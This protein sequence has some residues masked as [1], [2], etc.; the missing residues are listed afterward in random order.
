ML[1][2]EEVT[3]SKNETIDAKDS[4][5]RHLETTLSFERRTCAACVA[6]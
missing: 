4:L 5:I 1:L 3:K 2:V 6:E